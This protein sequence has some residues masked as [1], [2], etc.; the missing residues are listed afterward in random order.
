MS[1]RPPYHPLPLDRRC[2]LLMACCVLAATAVLGLTHKP[3]LARANELRPMLGGELLFQWPNLVGS[4]MPGVAAIPFIGLGLDVGGS[5]MHR[6]RWG[7]ALQGSLLAQGNVL[8][9]DGTCLDIYH[10]T[11]RFEARWWWM[12]RARQPDT[13]RM[14]FGLGVGY[15]LQNHND[16]F[17]ESKNMQ[18]TFYEP[19]QARPFLV[20][21]VGRMFRVGASRSE[22]SVRYMVHLDRSPAWTTTA[23]NGTGQATFNASGDH[24]ALVLRYHIGIRRAPGPAPPLP[25]VARERRELKAL[26]T[27][28]TR[29][30]HI[31]LW[32]KDNAEQDGD[33]L[34]ILLNGRPVLLAYALTN[35]WHRV[36]LDLAPG[37]NNVL[38]VAHNEGR[39]PPN[40][41]SAMLRTGRGRKQLLLRTGMD[42]SQSI[43]LWREDRP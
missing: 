27:L 20:P 18:F 37:P 28:H 31:V 9:A 42:A 36:D 16:G 35:R 8:C 7:F 1:V 34:S 21:E 23:S 3:H 33:T 43:V 40:T 4:T 24:L 12:L 17:N 32:V 30:E 6:E 13:H 10:G 25:A 38:V 2:V 11:Q 5:L 41:A 19:L 26:D 39:V 22:L 29:R 14:R 15:N